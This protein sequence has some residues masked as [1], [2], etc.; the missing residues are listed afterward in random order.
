VSSADLARID[1]RRI[2]PVASARAAAEWSMTGGLIALVAVIWLIPI[3]RYKLPVEL[4]FNLEV[5]RLL[6]LGLT[7]ALAVGI[8]SGRARLSAAG[9]AKPVLVLAV[10]ALAAQLVNLHQISAAGLQTQSLKSL[11]F[12]LSFLVAYLVVCSSIHRF[13]H[14]RAAIMAIVVCAVIVGIAAIYES[15]TRHNLS[16]DLNKIFPFLVPTGEDKSNI[17]QG[18]LRV[19]ASAQ[20]PIALAGVLLLTVPL[21]IYLA[22]HAA[23]K[24]RARLWLLGGVPIMVGG[25]AT[26]SR[27]AIVVLF[28]MVVV[29]LMFRRRETVR[30]W[31]VLIPL[32]GVLH[33][34]APGAMKG[35]YQAMTP[36]G[37]LI[38]QQQERPGQQG[39]GRIADLAIG[40]GRWKEAPIF[41]R[42]LGTSPTLADPTILDA[43]GEGLL[44]GVIY[45]DQYLTSLVSLGIVGFVG[46]VW[47]VWGAVIKLGKAARRTTGEVSDLLVACTAS[48]A[49]YAVGMATYDTLSFVQVTLLF[50][51]IVGIGLTARHLTRTS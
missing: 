2:L 44:I 11:S 50:F 46:I 49:G 22:R 26:V 51:V 10:C 48:A 32:V 39:S 38:S 5:Y 14:L 43:S 31:A 33:F 15:R 21:V 35:L 28:A 29:A 1:G 37:G 6:I 40:I 23:S 36:K 7:L 25:I 30:R 16:D 47:F 4:P 12:F 45:D 19:R 27:T 20:H 9:H 3:K 41:G 18:R 13:E 17:R 42:G 34:A 24:S 8:L